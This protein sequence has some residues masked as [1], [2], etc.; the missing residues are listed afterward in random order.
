[1]NIIVKRKNYTIITNEAVRDKRLSLKARGLLCFCMSLS[2]DWKY[3]VQGLASAAGVGVDTIKS[4]IKE[5]EQVG[6]LA[7]KKYRDE[8]GRM[9]CDYVIS[10]QPVK[11]EQYEEQSVEE[12]PTEEHVET[13]KPERENHGGKTTVEKPQWE[14][15][16]GSA[17]AVKPTLRNN[18]KEITKRNNKKEITRSSSSNN[19][20][21]NNARNDEPCISSSAAGNAIA[22]WMN[23]TGQFGE[24]IRSDISDLT[25]QYG[26]AVVTEAMREAIRS[27][28]RSIKY[29]TAI[30]ERMAS[31]K[32]RPTMINIPVANPWDAA[33]TK[34]YGGGGENG[35]NHG[36]ERS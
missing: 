2:D 21:Y 5:L 3:S 31:G 8:H 9:A 36:D 20:I 27:N 22:F 34:L 28:V 7:R 26:E 17:M 6:Y 24:V 4:A 10:D 35:N 14:N 13:E 30:V 23:N 25:E 29:V 11:A 32:E 15:R 33:F 19:N 1:M 12:Q 18:N 16:S